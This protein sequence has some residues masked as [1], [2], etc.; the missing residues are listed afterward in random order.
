MPGAFSCVQ[1]PLRNRAES[2]QRGRADPAIPVQSTRRNAIGW[3]AQPFYALVSHIHGTN[4][5]DV[6]QPAGSHPFHDAPEIR[7]GMNLSADLC[8]DSMF[9]NRSF[10]PGLAQE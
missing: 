8:D 6:P 3:I 9:L 10:L 4:E 5:A 1:L 2:T 7:L